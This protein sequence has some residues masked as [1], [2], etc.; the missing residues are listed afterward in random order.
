MG[1]YADAVTQILLEQ[2][3]ARAQGQLGSGQAWGQMAQQLGQIPNQM[4]AQQ[5]Q[6]Q[7]S[8]Q[9]IATA[10]AA[11]A[12]RQAQAKVREQA[13]K[14]QETLDALYKNAFVQDPESGTFTFKRDLVEQGLAQ[15]GQGHLYPKIMADLDAMDTAAQAGAAKRRTTVAQAFHNVAKQGYT[16]ESA[17][18][19]LAYLKQNH[20]IPEDRM[21]ALQDAI[22]QDGSPAGIQALVARVGGALPEYGALVNAEEKRLADLAHVKAQTASLSGEKGFKLGPG[23]VQFDQYGGEI[24][25]VEPKPPDPTQIKREWDEYRAQGGTLG[26]NDYQTMDANR[27]RPLSVT[28]AATDTAMIT[29]AA[30]NILANPRDL[31]SIKTITSLR[32]DQRLELF[33]TLKALDPTFNVGNIDRQIKFLDSYEDPKGRAAS[34]RGAMNN[35]LMHASDLSGVNEQYRRS[36]LRIVNTPIAA[37]Q[38]QGGT[39]WQ[40]FATPLAVLKD[41]IALYF[42]GGY[43]PSADQ[44]KT[45]DRIANDT[46]TPAQIEQFAKDIIH[47]GL[48]RADTHNE[49]FKTM[50]GYDDP[51][52]IT[53]H[54]VAAGER[55]GLGA[56]VKKYGSGGRIGAP[57][58]PAPPAPPVP[59]GMMRIRKIGTTHSAVGPRGP[60]PAGYEEVR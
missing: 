51:N 21:Q 3:Q 60:I 38:K 55:L 49:A 43:A 11:E 36:N 56:E 17:L 7:E 39:E 9:K 1:R 50:M 40:Q 30:R 12:D 33:N 29:Q 46:A 31:T 42:A 13:T 4:I 44:Q 27:K 34:N 54:A 22:A 14:N 48:R 19:N 32:G 23:D 35:I 53:P 41:E 16:T 37:L 15:S 2:G 26:F 58:A 20:L 24:A 25:R 5:Q 52:L 45:W 10:K 57:S 18:S 8:Q 6:L 28:N 59:A 47:V